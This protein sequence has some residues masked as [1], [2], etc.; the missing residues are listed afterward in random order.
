MDEIFR[1]LNDSSRRHLLDALRNRD[2]QSLSD[3]STLLPDMTRHG[4]MNHLRVL[5]EG[6]LVTTKKVGRYRLHYLNA[7]PI[8]QVHDRWISQYT[9][10]W[11]D[12][13]TALSHQLDEG[14]KYMETPDHRYQAFIRCQPTEAWEAIVDGSQTV[15][16]FFN[17]TVESDWTVGSPI[18]YL[19]ADGSVAADG[20]V[21][22]ID[23]PN[24]LEMT[25]LAHWD[26][27][28]EAE[29]PVRTV[30]LVDEEMGVTTVTVEYYGMDPAGATYKDFVAGIAF[31]VSGMKTL[32]ETGQPIAAT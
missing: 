19:A 10:P 17:T 9:Q 16:Y 4:V 7:V 23:P 3:L 24:R 12:T 29:G 2:G 27:A 32:L 5:E 13:L 26:P 6:G 18:R 15:K 31:I 1:A 22:A 8:Q 20:E 28:L 30:W 25:F 14:N 21:V 11:I